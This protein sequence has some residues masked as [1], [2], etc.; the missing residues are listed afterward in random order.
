MGLNLFKVDRGLSLNPQASSPTSPANGD[1][2]FDTTAGT[3]VIRQ[4]GT[5][6]NLVSKADVA[7]AA[8]M[9]STDF[10]AAKV[11]NSLIRVTGSTAGDIHG[12]AGGSDAKV[13]FLTNVSTQT[14]TIKHQSGTEAS[15]ANRIIVPNAADAFLPAGYSALLVYDSAQTRWL[16]HGADIT[17]TVSA[18]ANTLVRAN[19]TTGH[20]IKGTG[21][22]V[23]DSNNL[24]NA[25]SIVVG[26]ASAAA[27]ALL[28]ADST[29][30]GFLEPRMTTTQRDAISSPA[31]GLQ[32]YNTTT[33]ALNVYN[34]TAWVAVGTG[35][36]SGINY[37]TN[38]DAETDTTGWAE[39]ADAAQSRP[40][41]GT[42]G[43]PTVTWTRSA[44]SPLRGLGS[45]LFTKDAANRQGQGAAYAFTID[46]ADKGKILNI[47]A[48]WTLV[49]GTYS[50]GTSTTDSD[51]IA[52]IYDVTN[53]VVIE[54]VPIKID[55]GL[56]GQNYKFQSSF[57]SAVNSNS[58]RLI[59]HCATTSALAYVLKF[60]NIV[61]GPN[62]PV[63]VVPKPNSVQRFTSGSAQTYTT[64]AGCYMLKVYTVG[65]GGGGGASGTAGGGTPTAGSASTFGPTGNTS[66]L[67]AS[68]GNA[69]T[70]RNASAPNGSGGTATVSAP[71]IQ[72]KAQRGGAASGNI[73]QTTTGTSSSVNLGGLSAFG[74]N[75]Y[76]GFGEGSQDPATNSGSGGGGGACGTTSGSA[77]GQGGGA[78]GYIEAII[79]NPVTNYTYT[80]GGGGSGSSAGTNGFSGSAGAAGQIIVEEYYL[81]SNVLSASE[82]DTRVVSWAAF[83][84]GSQTVGPSGS[85]IKIGYNSVTGA[86]TKDTH[87]LFDTTNNRYV[88]GVP[89]DYQVNASFFILSTNVLANNYQ[90]RIFVNGSLYQVGFNQTVT[91][92]AQFSGNVSAVV[93]NLKIGDYI[94][95]FLFGAGDNSVNT[96]TVDSGSQTTRFSGMRISGPNQVAATE[97]VAM[98]YTDDAVQALQTSNT[99]FKFGTK[100]F[101]T[102][103]AYSTSTGLFTVPI[104]G[105]YLITGRM[106]TGNVTTLTTSQSLNTSIFKNG[107]I[108]Q[109]LQWTNGS[110]VVTAYTS[111][112]SCTIN[113]K[114]GDTLGFYVAISVAAN[115][116]N[117]GGGFG[118]SLDITR[119][120]N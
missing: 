7:S 70:T 83:R 113:C 47:S 66:M 79:M 39:Y 9:T 11:Q 60:D 29:T 73:A 64:P 58:Y 1:V 4:N 46:D 71:A 50:S 72:L 69:G 15:T 41:D 110:G 90:A 2:Y 8:S 22:T 98:R 97:T 95:I 117:S 6:I 82:T 68:G 13:L 27:S 67:S 89:G 25:T 53:A 91:A 3:F 36:G 20:A 21:I 59:L 56:V 114:A 86:G 28:Q 119:I 92:G 102:H 12:L 35:T 14:Q 116:F 16:F 31:T 10:T 23:D 78:G 85:N 43:S 93:T 106:M 87:G 120:G 38:G 30:K 54:P 81:G 94:E 24:A 61:L 77:G 40:V 88:I 62:Q 103:N 112:G 26:A 109:F 80:V 57:Q 17:G 115:S 76:G 107:A 96:L 75:A 105:K 100:D 111:G 42:G 104:S 51:L 33:N 118:P 63:G 32:V 5:F 45:F 108:A 65:G 52:Y 49:S 37:I 48:D 34:G 74:G 101:D 99:V 18:T 44:S 55:G 84:S 19:G